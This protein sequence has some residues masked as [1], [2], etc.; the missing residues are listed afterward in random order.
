MKAAGVAEGSAAF[1]ARHVEMTFWWL[2]SGRL[3]MKA[4]FLKSLSV[5]F[6]SCA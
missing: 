5:E 1:A 4:G 6:L 2:F 3:Y